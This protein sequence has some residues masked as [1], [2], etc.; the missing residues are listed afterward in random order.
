MAGFFLNALDGEATNLL[1]GLGF[2]FE[3][4]TLDAEARFERTLGPKRRLVWGGSARHNQFDLTL[5][6]D[7]SR[8]D[9]AGVFGQLEWALGGG[10]IL[11]LGG[12]LDAV[13]RMGLVPSPRITFLSEPRRGHTLRASYGQA[14][15]AP[16]FLQQYIDVEFENVIELGTFELRFP[17]HVEG[18]R[19]LNESHVE[20][21]EVGYRVRLGRALYLDT[22]A[23]WTREKNV[24]DLYAAEYW[25]DD[26]LPPWW[27]LPP[28]WFPEETLP[29]RYTYRNLATVE[30]IG[31]ELGLEASW[32]E[33]WSGH[34]TY[35]WQDLPRVSSLKEA[36]DYNENYPARHRVSVGADFRGKRLI[37]SVSVHYSD[38]AFWTDVLDSRFYAWTDTWWR[39]NARLT[40]LSPR[41]RFR[42]SVGGTNLGNDQTPQHA[43]GDLIGRQVTTELRWRF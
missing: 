19:D 32:G 5:G 6:P 17:T 37:G 15:H 40:W 4:W 29:K 43:F 25:T 27:T 3:T 20:S 12:R 24:Q 10:S 30:D 35:S 33:R 13:D 1:N 21:A 23:Y 36:T 28:D 26:P 2:T 16:S 34:L 14:F 7:G 11:Y 41:D 38:R 22:A 8:R 39:Y 18:K 9:E 31:F 42:W